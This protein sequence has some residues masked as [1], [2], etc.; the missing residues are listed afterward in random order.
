[1]R[2]NARLGFSS[3]LEFTADL[4]RQRADDIPNSDEREFTDIVVETTLAFFADSFFL[5]YLPQDFYQ[6]LGK[7]SAEDLLRLCGFAYLGTLVFLSIPGPK[8]QQI[9]SF[10]NAT[11]LFG[12]SDHDCKFYSEV[13][14]MLA[15][16]PSSSDTDYTF[17]SRPQHECDLIFAVDKH[18]HPVLSTLWVRLQVPLSAR[19]DLFDAEQEQRNLGIQT[20]AGIREPG[21][22]PSDSFLQGISA[23]EAID[24]ERSPGRQHFIEIRDA[25]C[26]DVLSRAER[27]LNTRDFELLR[28]IVAAT[29]DFLTVTI[30]DTP[31]PLE[32]YDHLSNCTQSE[33]TEVLGLTYLHTILLFSQSDRRNPV[34][35]RLL[36]HATSVFHIRPYIVGITRDTAKGVHRPNRETSRYIPLY[37]TFEYFFHLTRRDHLDFVY[38]DFLSLLSTLAQ[39]IDRDKQRQHV[40]ETEQ[41]KKPGRLFR[42]FLA[43]FMIVLFGIVLALFVEFCRTAP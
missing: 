29:T 40:L 38:E 9:P 8:T 34:T 5:N 18:Y 11:W 2:H 10:D 16:A 35:T 1:M 33:V 22:Y 43:L 20:H 42:I 37:S 19:L 31:L 27:L 13:A 32:F 41:A 36:K 21:D 24:A 39:I 3:L 28:D 15:V 23:N 12:L 6:D 17:L 4:Y 14:P 25:A 26:K 7:V 30:C